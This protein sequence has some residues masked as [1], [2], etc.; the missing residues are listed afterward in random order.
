MSEMLDLQGARSMREIAD[1][2]LETQRVEYLNE[3]ELIFVPPPSETHQK[4]VR[5]LVRGFILAPLPA[6]QDQPWDPA[7]N[8]QWEIGDGSGR[9][10]IPDLAV[11]P[12]GLEIPDFQP[13]TELLVEVTSPKSPVTVNNDKTVKPKL[14]ARAGVP[15]YLLVDQKARTWTLH[16]LING[17]P[18][19][20]IHSSGRYGEDGDPIVLPEP[21]GFS[22]PTA[23][24]PPY[25]ADEEARRD[26]E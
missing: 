5:K 21:F 16:Q 7:E 18:K 20:K 14:Y 11:A 23:D 10:T 1:E 15:L 19:Y 22:I 26:A 13:G 3:G 9:Y 6:G 17:W 24:W 25:S 4:I 8:I 12:D 2:L